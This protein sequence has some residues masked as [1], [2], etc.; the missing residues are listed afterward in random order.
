VAQKSDLLQR[1]GPA[2][3]YRVPAYATVISDLLLLDHH[4]LLDLLVVDL[5]IDRVLLKHLLVVDPTTRTLSPA[6]L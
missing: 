6:I 3:S 4:H 1:L 2:K 5:R